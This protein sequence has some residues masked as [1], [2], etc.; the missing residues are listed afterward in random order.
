MIF[1]P[2]NLLRIVLFAVS[3]IL[4]QKSLAQVAEDQ[5]IDPII[6]S[7]VIANPDLPDNVINDISIRLSSLYQDKLDLNRGDLNLLSSLYLLNA[8][9]V[10]DIQIHISK[11]GKLI[12][13]LELQS[14]PSISLED[15]IR[16]RPFLKAL[17]QGAKTPF[18][19]SMLY[20]GSKQ[21]SVRYVRGIEEKKGYAGDPPPY[22]GSPDR[23][24]VNLRHS[25]SYRVRWG[26]SM[27]K[28]AGEPFSRDYNSLYFDYINFYLNLK[29]LSPGIKELV[30]GDFQ[31]SMGQG[32]VMQSGYGFGKSAF[33]TNIKKSGLGL[34]ASTGINEIDALR[35]AGIDMKLNRFIRFMAFG[36]IRRTDGNLLELDTLDPDNREYAF[37]SFQTSG[38]HRTLSELADRGQIRQTTAGG[39][40]QFLKS[41]FSIGINGVGDWLDKKFVVTDRIYNRFYFNGKNAWNTSVD[42][43][44]ALRNFHF[45]GEAAMNDKKSIAFVQGALIGLHQKASLAILYRN[46]PAKYYALHG[47]AFT[48]Q[49]SPTNEKGLYVGLEV[50]PIAYLQVN[51]YADFYSHDWATFQATAPSSGHDYLVKLSYQKRKKWNTYIQIKYSNDEVNG[52]SAESVPG[53]WVRSRFNMRLHFSQKVG[54]L[55]TW[56]SR[57]EWMQF[58]L[59]D[60]R[61]EHGTLIYQEFW[62]QPMGKPLSGF[63]RFTLFNTD[64]YDSRIYAY[65]HYVAY[66]SRNTPFYGS[67]SRCNAGL[68]YKMYNGITIEAVYNITKYKNTSVIGSGNE[69]INGPISSDVRLQLRYSLN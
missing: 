18:A 54:A 62:L 51:A 10:S 69:Q 48:D 55:L 2:N 41:G 35:G 34:R 22:L 36:S 31:A 63:V 59:A 53:L 1:K 20:N 15:I 3:M 39:S 58:Q 6:E 37:S 43:S 64:S 7:I 13:Y 30:V 25:S 56:N 65:E 23:L 60:Q 17:D 14:I 27:E 21:L 32:L 44:Y 42:Y 24:M 66:D 29:D 28:D 11:Y 61:Q 46:L 67:G 12:S 40:L 50:R 57:V 19:W 8:S 33:S 47:N 16:I 4:M 68:R 49:S 38:L 26:L 9:Q 5:A 45:F 52:S